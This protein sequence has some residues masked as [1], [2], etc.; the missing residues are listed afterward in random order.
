MDMAE[1]YYRRVCIGLNTKGDLIHE[2]AVFYVIKD[3]DKPSYVSLF[4]YNEEQY[5]LFEQ[6]NTVSGIKDVVTNSLIWDFDSVNDIPSAQ[7]DASLLITRLCKE[8][9]KPSSIQIYFSGN[10]GFTIQVDLD[11]DIKPAELKTICIDYFGKDLDTLDRS[12]YNASRIIRIP[13]TKHE[14]GLYKIPLSFETFRD[15]N[16]SDILELAK[17]QENG[18]ELIYTSEP[19]VDA[20]LTMIPPEKTN[21]PVIPDGSIPERPN[22]W[23][24]CKWNLFQGNFDAGER[25]QALMVI[26]ATFRG[27]GYDKDSVYYNCKAALK[28]QAAR[29]G[30]E[31]FAKEELYKNIVDESIF[32]NNWNG[33]TYSCK[34]DPWLQGYCQKLGEHGC[35]GKGNED[36]GCVEFSTMTEV[37]N[38]YA[39]N[40]DKN[41]IKTGINDLDNNLTLVCSTL[42]GLLGQPGAGKTSAA[43]QILRATSLSGVPSIFFSMDMGLPIVYGKLLQRETGKSLKEVMQGIKTED[44]KIMDLVPKINDEY[45]NVSFCF[46]SAVSVADMKRQIKER[47]DITGCQIKLVVI[48][49]LEC[50]AGP[51]AEA[52]ANTGFIANQLKDL[53]NSM[54]VCVLLL[55]QT[56]KHST[57]DISDPLLT[58]KGVKGSSII[59]QSC[60]T[61]TTLWREGYSPENVANDKYMSFAVVKNRFGSLWKGDFFWN[62]PKGIISPLT[63]AQEYE[64]K[65][66]KEEKKE[67][68][69][70]QN[71]NNGGFY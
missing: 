17:K 49:Y 33:G 30:Q 32:S 18:P 38:N 4:K 47:Q 44:Q 27:F 52:T 67:K 26:A 1:N 7:S 19:I 61:I 46:Q 21:I 15:N 60:S 66:F 65:K 45:K 2:S 71:N 37:F 20:W 16:A 62:G 23:K 48:D 10:K 58:M 34:T 29:T 56:Q 22:N 25:H 51:Y 64:L 5:R 39:Q 69:A 50:I 28:K 63:D 24:A 59:E 11:E 35:Q 14:K 41:I 53:A 40:F 36:E 31:E 12:I 57:P 54:N 9:I 43:V 68:K 13:F 8:G 70:E 55:L 6:T 3:Y 42:N